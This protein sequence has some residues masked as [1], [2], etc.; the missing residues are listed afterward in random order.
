MGPRIVTVDSLP[1]DLRMIARVNGEQWSEGS[2]ADIMWSVAKLISWASASEPLRGGTLL[3][4]GPVATGCGLELGR[5]LSPGDVV[6]L[7][8]EGIGVLRN[9]LGQPRPDWTPEPRT[10]SGRY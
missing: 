7:E 5:E 8:I 1:D 3:G 10:S 4:S 9:T 2:S 6:E